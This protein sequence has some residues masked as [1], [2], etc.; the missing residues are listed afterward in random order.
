M[1]PGAVSPLKESDR[2][3]T[4]ETPAAQQVMLR[5]V[6]NLEKQVQLLQQQREAERE[7]HK[8]A[9]C[10]LKL[11]L[12]TLSQRTQEE[13]ITL[14]RTQLWGMSCT[15]QSQNFA[16]HRKMVS[17][18][19]IPPSVDAEK[20]DALQYSAVLEKL[21]NVLERG[22]DHLLITLTQAAESLHKQWDEVATRTKTQLH[23]AVISTTR[24]TVIHAQHAARDAIDNL[25]TTTRETWIQSEPLSAKPHAA[26]HVG[27]TLKAVEQVA[28][29]LASLQKTVV[30]E[31]SRVS[32]LENVALD[33]A[34]VLTHRKVGPDVAAVD[35]TLDPAVRQDTF[36]AVFADINGLSL[37][38]T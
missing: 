18:L 15:Q 23:D 19:N 1:S 2:V 3:E 26:T 29:A 34:V 24:Q 5:Q 4:A 31:L 20:S 25:R 16:L 8:N 33:R 12:E 27:L 35:I 22:L 14:S 17:C 13:K 6:M 38:V 11:E 37:V 30:D 21:D 32:G 10:S 7:E 9:V 36:C 28:V